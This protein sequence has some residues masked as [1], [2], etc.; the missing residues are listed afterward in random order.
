MARSGEA[1]PNLVAALK[2]RLT[3]FVDNR[4]RISPGVTGKLVPLTAGGSFVLRSGGE[5]DSVPPSE[6]WENYAADAEAYLADGRQ[7]V[8]AMLRILADHHLPR[9]RRV[10]DLGCSAGRLMRHLPRDEGMECWGVDISAP[11]IEWCQRHLPWGN[12]ATTTTAPH[13]P[14]EDGYFDLVYAWSVFTHISD[15]ADAWLLEVRRVLKEGGCAYLTVHDLESYEL[16]LRDYRDDPLI[17][18]FARSLAQFEESHRLKGASVD[19]FSFGSDPESQVFYDPRYLT[20]KWGRWM[21]QVAYLPQ[22]YNYQSVML[23]RKAAGTVTSP[24][25]P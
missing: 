7:D 4:I 3:S 14:F 1:R 17:G 11:H 12:F 25:K 6:L 24:A 13:L 16:I 5:A 9:P 8:D 18:P 2:R 23:L 19:A 15:L 21:E 22:A 20:A 10:L